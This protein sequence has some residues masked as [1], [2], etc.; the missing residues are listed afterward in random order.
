MSFNVRTE[1]VGHSFNVE[2]DE[3]ILAAAL[4]QGIGLPYGCR[5]GKCGSCT[6]GLVSGAVDY[7]SGKTEALA[8]Q[9]Q[10]ACL[11]C[12]A[13]PRG[14]LV[15]RVAVLERAADIEVRTLP[16][17]VVE[18]TLLNHDVMRLRL[19]LPE[20]QRLQFLAGQYI[21]FL[22]R[23]GRRRAFSLA[24]APFDD[25]LLE[26]H[27]RQVP[28]GEFTDYVF[29]Q[30]QEKAILRIHGPLGSFV[31]REA[32]DRPIILIGG[33]TG[34]APLKGLIEHAFHIGVQRPMTLYWGARARRDLYLPDLPEA[35]RQAHPTFHYVPV[36]SEPDP[37]WTGRRGYVHEAVVEDHPDIAAHDVYVSGPPVMVEAAR[38]AFEALGLGL[39]H[40]FSDAFEYAA[41]KD[42]RGADSA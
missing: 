24:N 31:L 19:K 20:A 17:R 12:Q 14:D 41:D 6:A 26:L 10:D 34:F 11:T 18:K 13:V 39:D 21:E 29:D 38:A 28:G 40:L 30:L 32:S 8:G 15:L 9:A 7:P 33:G 25:A 36:L 4:R 16:C 3:T 2:A 42:V 23:D 22:L 5:D 37:D 27:V 35:W 1:P